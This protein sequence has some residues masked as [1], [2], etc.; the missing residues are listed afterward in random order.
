MFNMKNEKVISGNL[1]SV[2]VNDYYGLNYVQI[3]QAPII[4]VGQK[5]QK[6]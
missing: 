5:F 1:N 3:L 6:L 4:Y 2:N